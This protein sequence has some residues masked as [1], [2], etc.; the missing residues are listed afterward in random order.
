MAEG[1]LGS[2]SGK[3]SRRQA[4]AARW[5]VVAMAGDQLGDFSDLFTGAPGVRRAA[6]SSPAVWGMWGRFWFVLPNPV[7]G[8]G[9]KG[10]VDDVFP[11][12]RRWSAA[13]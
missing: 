9:L 8:T 7:Y 13:P 1:D 5:C 10:G 11:A 6:A 4:I 3:D 2:G 12:D